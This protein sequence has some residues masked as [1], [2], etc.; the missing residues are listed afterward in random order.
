MNELQT[1]VF[2]VLLSALGLQL[3]LN[4][5][6]FRMLA[7]N[8][9]TVPTDFKDSISLADH[10]KAV[11]YS[12]AKLKAGSLNLIVDTLVVMILTLGG[13]LQ[14]IDGIA[15]EY[16]TDDT[17]RA[18][19]VVFS[20]LLINGLINLPFS[21]YRTFVIEE[22]YGFNKTT[23]SLYLLD[24]LKI[25]I[26]TL[27]L[28]IPLLWIILWFMT[29]VTHWWAYAAATLIGFSLL[30]SWL[31]PTLIAPLFNRFTPL[32]DKE[33]KERI[34][35]LMQDT[36]FQSKGI[37]LMDGSRR[38][39]HGNA[40]FTGLGNNKRIV[41]FDTLLKQLSPNEIEA[42]LAHE[43]GHF[44]EKHIIKG[45]ILSAIMTTIGFFI[46]AQLIQ[47]PGF[48][49][50]AQIQTPSNYM[51][52][53]LF[54]MLSPYFMIWITPLLNGISRRHEYEADSF[55]ARHAQANDLIQALLKMYRD[56]ASPVVTDKFYS[57]FHDS[58]PP[59][60]LRIQQL[61]SL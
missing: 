34:N 48:Y 35:R 23:L 33:L 24:L 32:E 56:N 8:K 41:F 43:L 54:M 45:M 21:A 15:R 49:Q 38:S 2:L 11:T 17:L 39:A 9:N 58:H 31:F 16:L 19:S 13:G 37:Y 29:T 27:L 53:I 18:I 25:L 20:V 60:S 47:W 6:Q 44:R 5:R 42:V 7:L 61:Q 40:Y 28:A 30:M 50:L 4:L 59:A 52:L 57:L 51:A 46:L 55:S 12:S 1:S 3:W 26:L 14:Y 22:R 36:G 10:Q